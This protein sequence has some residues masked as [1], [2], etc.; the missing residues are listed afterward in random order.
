[1]F[2]VTKYTEIIRKIYFKFIDIMNLSRMENEEGKAY[3]YRLK[4][5]GYE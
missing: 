4:H 1:M 5:T 3:L 2:S